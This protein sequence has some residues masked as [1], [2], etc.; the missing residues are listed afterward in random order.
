M[1]N[2]RNIVIIAGLL[3]FGLFIYQNS[4]MSKSLNQIPFSD[5]V[6]LVKEKKVSVATIEEEKITFITISQDEFITIMPKIYP[7]LTNLLYDNNVKFKV[8]ESSSNG[9]LFN[10]LIQWLPMIVLVVIWIVFMRQMQGGNRIMGF[11]QIKPKKQ[12]KES[13]TVTF[14][15]VA[16]IDEA[17]YELVEIVEF[18]KNPKKF[19]NLGGKVPHG[20]LLCGQPGTGKTLLARAVAGEAKVSFFKV[21]GSD[22]VEMFVGVG[23]SRVRDI[24]KQARSQPPCIIFIDEIDAVGRH[25]GSG[26]GGGNDEREQT[27]NQILV[28]MDGFQVNS[29]II[30]IAATNRPDTLDPALTRPGRFDRTVIV[31]LPDKNGRKKI[32]EV[33]AKKVKLHPD[34]SLESIASS[35]QGFTGADLQ[36][37]VNE[38]A[39]LA[40]R[41]AKDS[42]TEID[43]EEA[44]DKILLGT[45]RKSLTMSDKELE[46]TAY[47][48]AG[49]ALI[50]ALSEQLDVLH[51]VT[52]IPRGRTLGVTMLL[53]KDNQSLLTKGKLTAMLAMLMGGRA[54]EETIYNH[55]TTGAHNDLERATE[56][57]HRMVCNWGMSKKIGPFYLSNSNND[58]FLG[59]DMVKQKKMSQK[60]ALLV[61][62]E[63]KMIVNKSYKTALKIIKNNLSTLHRLAKSL[64]KEET[65]SGEEVLAIIKQKST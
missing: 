16:G 8:V 46:A 32:L 29:G 44:R 42:L 30:V 55:F 52:I 14:D 4:Q 12:S 49:H 26:L 64:L 48:E 3:L 60:T 1:K 13:S 39:L 59:R 41:K 37:L 31:N 61:D 2:Q 38:A 62:K 63:V 6:T 34:I 47:H 5:F 33:H 21:S 19:Q 58:V 10:I 23:A 9:L 27:L 43:F 40:G 22:F 35:T 36:N 54:A 57:S 24:F 18:L 15:D 45:E 7:G 11:G 56:Y 65:L 51:K 50:A 20:V 28:E 17:K 53:P 25:R